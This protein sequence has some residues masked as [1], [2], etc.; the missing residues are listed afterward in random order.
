MVVSPRLESALGGSEGAAV[1]VAAGVGAAESSV[2][3]AWLR[4]AA[5]VVVTVVEE[6]A[7]VA[8]KLQRSAVKWDAGVGHSRWAWAS[9]MPSGCSHSQRQRQ[10]QNATWGVPVHSVVAVAA[11][12]LVPLAS[13]LTACCSA[14][15]LHLELVLMPVLVLAHELGPEPELEPACSTCAVVLVPAPP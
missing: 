3:H 13:L 7:V 15:G 10:R 9:V 4:A 1:A 14:L 5:G 8:Q 12:E 6:T 11:D 2:A